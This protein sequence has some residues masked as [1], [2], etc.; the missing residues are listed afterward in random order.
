MP[1]PAPVMSAAFPESL[2]ATGPSPYH[3]PEIA[4]TT[5]MDVTLVWSRAAPFFDREH[6][7]DSAETGTDV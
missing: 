7:V 5:S 6:V 2:P 1:D 3:A 4:P